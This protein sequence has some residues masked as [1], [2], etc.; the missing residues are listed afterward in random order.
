[1]NVRNSRVIACAVTIVILLTATVAIAQNDEKPMVKT[2]ARAKFGGL[3]VLPSC[4]TFAV[5]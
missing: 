3:P 4:A 5:E 1:M 2:A